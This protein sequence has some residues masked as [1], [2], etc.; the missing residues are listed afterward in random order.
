[1]RISCVAKAFAVLV[2][3]ASAR[4]DDAASEAATARG[5]MQFTL[6]TMRDRAKSLQDRLRLARRRGFV[7][8][9]ACLDRALS[10]ADVA[11]RRA[12]EE[13]EASIAAYA[14]GAIVPAR[15]AR[16]HVFVLA[17][18]QSFV[19]RDAL[20]C[21]SSLAEASGTRV[22]LDVAKSIPRVE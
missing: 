16:S 13:E 20:A 1:M 17:N 11:V 14:R 3:V 12:R 6:A 21:G 22:S 15:L 2:V 18:E 4:A 10:R 7:A 9:I 19:I 8:E 5:E